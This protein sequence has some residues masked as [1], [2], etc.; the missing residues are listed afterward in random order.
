MRRFY[1]IPGKLHF[2][3][4]IIVY[5]P[6]F[7]TFNSKKH[8]DYCSIKNINIIFQ[9]ALKEMRLIDDK[10][11]YAINQSIPTASFK[12]QSD[13]KENCKELSETVSRFL[14]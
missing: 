6:K 8:V 2:L 1:A 10:I 13:A 9:T 12:G 11:V 14:I 5:D 7:K 4:R 3:M